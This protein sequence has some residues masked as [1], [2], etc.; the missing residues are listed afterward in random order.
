LQA[1]ARHSEAIDSYDKV[2]ALRPDH[3]NAWGNRGSALQTIERLSDALQSYER[4]LAFD[5]HNIE[6]LNNRG[7]ALADL[8]RHAEAL[9]HYD[10]ALAIKPDYVDAAWNKS[11]LLLL[12]GRME[13]GWPLYESRWNR[14]GAPPRRSFDSAPWDGRSPVAG[15]SILLYAD[16]GLGDTIH[17]SRYATLLAA[18][19]ARV[20]LQVP[21]SLVRLLQSLDARVAVVA[22]HEP[23]PPHD[24]NYALTSL[25]LAFHTTLETIPNA[26]PYLT[27]DE[28]HCEK[29]SARLGARTRP[30]IGL[31]WSGSSG[32]K[33]DGIRSIP[34]SLL[35]DL[36]RW[37]ADW[38]CLQKDIRDS[39]RESLAQLNTVRVFAS[40]LESFEDTA[41]LAQLCD[42]VISVDT[43]VAHLAGALGRPLWILLPFSPDWRWLTDREDSPWYPTARLFR[44]PTP[45]AWDKVIERVRAALAKS[46][47]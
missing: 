47:I 20:I 46:W 42:L 44:Q 26:T 17:F 16:Q 27:A 8:G 37:P 6:I 2:I 30:R 11:V 34:L 4:A 9:V 13:E 36:V 12:M 40:E 43:S 39:D 29:W 7:T 24:V 28:Q 32:L 18:Q 31:V 22:E 45:G 25:P 15:K 5:A 35:S 41:A 21:R 14:T 38:L 3:A 10:R 1:L 33:T 19:E 23:V